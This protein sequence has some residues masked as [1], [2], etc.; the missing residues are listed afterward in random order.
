MAVPWM[1]L[2]VSLSTFHLGIFIWAVIRH[3]LTVKIPSGLQQPFKLRFLHCMILYMFA[4]GD[5]LEKLR[6]C[7][8]LK[9]IQFMHDVTVVKK[10]HN[11]VVTN[12]KFGTIPVRLFQPKAVSSKLR[13][14]IIF[15]HGGGTICGSLDFYHNL[16]SFLAQETDSVVLSVGY[17]K[18][19]DHHHPSLSKD[20][21]N[22]SI[23]FM[24]GLKTYGVDPSRVVVCGESIGG[25]AVAVVIQALLNFPSLP[26]ICAQVLITPGI[27]ALN[28][29]LP[30]HQQHQNVPLLTKDILMMA[31]CKYLDID[32]SWKDAII[33]GTCIPPD[34]WKKYRK[35]IGSDN[36]PGRF[37]S[38]NLLPEFPGPFNEAAY[39][40]TKHILEAE[41]SPLLVDDKII[42]QLPKAFLVSCEYDPLRDH[43]LL[44]KKRL[45]DQGVPV[46]WYHVED[47]FHGCIV[48]FDK[49]P[50]SFPCSIKIVNALVGY[51][52]DL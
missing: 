22:A 44:Y 30:S 41:M 31:F 29:L 6:I 47:G 2:L 38:K 14:G 36:I 48:L 13:R 26:Q 15:Y 4:L 32:L 16:C 5:I 35:W 18:L 33:N 27:Q 7:S 39:L 25:G 51:I 9:F 46:T 17:R 12:M 28:L 8:M 45:E 11:L 24:K 23:H 50:F 21:L 34:I 42:A 37:K 43:T 19:P 40:E 10:N 3:F 49:H 1:L 20:C 52:N